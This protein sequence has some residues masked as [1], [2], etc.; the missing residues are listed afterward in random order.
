METRE[1][2]WSLDRYQ[3]V[4][5]YAF[6]IAAMGIFAAAVFRHVKKYSRGR[7]LPYVLE[8]GEGLSRM[9]G[10]VF[11]HRTVRRRDRLA[12]LAHAG[13]F[14][15]FFIGFL[16]TTLIFIDADIL[17]PLFNVSVWQGP[18]YL[19]SSLALDLGH[20]V[21]TI[22][23]VVLMWRRAWLKPAKLEYLR[24]Y[25]SETKYRRAARGWRTED[26][27]FAGTFLIIELTGF[28]LQ[29]LR[30]LMERPPA[31]DW[32]PAGWA[33]AEILSGLGMAEAGAASIRGETWWFHAVLALGFTAA[34]PI[35]KGKH[36]L[37]VLASLTVRNRR[38]LRQLPKEDPD[39]ESPGVGGLEDLTWKDMLHLDACTKCGRCHEV[40]P[41]QNTGYPLSPRDLILDLRTYNDQRQGIAECGV[42]L[43][44]GVIDTET[45]WA[46]MACGAC[47]EICPVG[48]EHPDL[49]VRLR[50]HLI[51]QGDMDPMLRTALANVADT[52]NSFGESSRARPNWTRDLEFRVKDIREE[53]AENLWFVGDFASFDPR[54]QKVSRT[55]ARLFKAARLDFGLL[56][57]SERTAGNDIRRVGEEGLFESLAG[58]NIAAM[59]AAQPFRRIITTDPHSYN[60]IRNEYPEF[61]EVAPIEHYTSVLV[62]LLRSERLK[63]RKPLNRRVTFHDPCHLGRLNGGYDAPREVLSLIG[64]EL[65][66]MP[67]NRDNSFCCGAGG[68]RIW[69]PDD[70]NAE[71]PSDNR[72]R[73][74]AALSDI[75]VFVTCCPKDLTMFEDARKTSGH[76][77][78]FV[79][80]DLAELVAEAIELDMIELKDLPP[81]ADRI[82]DA[83]A[84]RIAD[85]V[86]NRLEQILSAHLAQAAAVQQIADRTVTDPVPAVPVT[87]EPG[88]PLVPPSLPQ[89]AAAPVVL[90]PMN[91]DAPAPIRPMVFDDY[92]APKKTGLRLLVTIKHAAILGDDHKIR[93]DGCDVEPEYL[94]HAMN[95]WD[96][97]AL[98]EALLLVERLGGGEVVAVSVGPEGADDSLRKALAKGAERAVRIW[99]NGFEML[100]P[101][102]IAAAIAGIAQAESPDL[103]L[104]GVQS[105]D[106]ANGATGAALARILGLP[107]AAVVIGVNWDGGATLEAVRELEGGLRHTIRLGAPAV[108]SIQTGANTPRFATMRMIK[109]ARK[110]EIFVAVPG[111]PQDES[112]TV[113]VRRM[114][115]PEKTRAKMLEGSPADVAAFVAAR[116]HEF[117]GE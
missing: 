81:L 6:G 70:P 2:F 93:P 29:G 20:I 50:R 11:T 115:E 32:S 103:I 65:V 75:D 30:I 24:S 4:L 110:K 55:V 64:C 36:I 112:R 19:L 34:I 38:A 58:D 47:M 7:P 94:D 23:I 45:L 42:N 82:V 61:G 53:P 99:S 43:A 28:F 12:G 15:G 21:A 57:E 109:Q 92:T 79:V 63:V 37:A 116:I 117:K 46:C 52:G 9:V 18:V 66:E 59:T 14:T 48:I 62:D 104:T 76:E 77:E 68:G 102:S 80:Q 17:R 111:N 100:D 56:H 39:S 8:L 86:A 114:Y 31:A 25:R 98:E 74:A 87:G 101:V 41:A 54:N 113:A 73:E 16:S 33:V 71:K 26:W 49:I 27:I 105:S 3:I 108:L 1:L 91:W 84:G 10:D 40:C 5:F 96:D 69:M 95:E 106:H 78:S 60:T 44:G 90:V 107:Q 72:M 13:V 35:F 89:F 88:Q 85:T 67:R 22:G 83:V 51:E 97:T